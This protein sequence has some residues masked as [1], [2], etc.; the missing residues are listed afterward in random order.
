MLDELIESD[1][2]QNIINDLAV[3]LNARIEKVRNQ[4]KLKF[5]S[6]KQDE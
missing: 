3:Q 4:E 5:S 2:K 1:A 6:Q